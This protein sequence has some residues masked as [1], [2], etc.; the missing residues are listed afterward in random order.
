M[1]APKTAETKSPRSDVDMGL[2]PDLMGFNLR[3]AQLTLFQHFGKTVGREGISPPQFGTLLLIEANP[4][5]SQSAVAEAL[6]FDRSTLVQIIDR[7]EERGLVVRNVSPTDRRSHAL[8]LTDKGTAALATL[9]N[10]ALAHEADV[11][12]GL[13]DAERADLIALLAKLHGGA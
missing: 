4:D 11:A 5:I 12:A 1:A 2:L 8:R 9:K 10:L 7:L 13:S 3:C 6:R